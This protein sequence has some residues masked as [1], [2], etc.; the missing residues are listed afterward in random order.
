MLLCVQCLRKVIPILSLIAYL[1]VN[2][3]IS[4]MQGPW[5]FV[6]IPTPV[7]NAFVSEILPH[8][9]FITTALF[10]KFIESQDE[11]ALVLGHEVS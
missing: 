7:P 6:L 10:D 1:I 11:L 2:G 5:R 8:R 3:L 4:S 9:I